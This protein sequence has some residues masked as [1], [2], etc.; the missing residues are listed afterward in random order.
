MILIDILS[1]IGMI[2]MAV[3]GGDNDW[4]NYWNE[5]IFQFGYFICGVC[6]GINWPLVIVYIKEMYPHAILE[7]TGL[8]GWIPE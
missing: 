4:N 7:K 3:G 6:G 5:P 8:D 1:I 2:T